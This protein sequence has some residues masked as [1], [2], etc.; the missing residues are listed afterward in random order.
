MTKT[1]LRKMLAN[2]DGL[3]KPD[4]HSMSDSDQLLHACLLTYVKHH[5]G[6]DILGWS[7]LAETLHN[8]ICQ[9]IGDEEYCRWSD[10]IRDEVV[11]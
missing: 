2:H 7:K 5:M 6:I 9:N 1:A 3:L 11:R 8:A 10:R 4:W